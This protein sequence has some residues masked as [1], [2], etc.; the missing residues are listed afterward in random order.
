MK[1]QLLSYF[2]FVIFLL[3]A[4]VIL[5]TI[6]D[7]ILPFEDLFD[8]F[9]LIPAFVYMACL[10]YFY[11]LGLSAAL[12][13]VLNQLSALRG[14]WIMYVIGFVGI[15][16]HYACYGF[17]GPALSFVVLACIFA[18]LPLCVAYLFGHSISRCVAR[19]ISR[20]HRVA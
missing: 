8:G 7:R 13:G 4:V 20:W 19:G 18:S 15:A 9:G 3:S 6:E 16:I 1:S 17:S 11:T 2:G 10:S 14:V 12:A 5:L